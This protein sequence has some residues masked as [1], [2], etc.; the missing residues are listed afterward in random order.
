F[1][2]GDRVYVYPHGWGQVMNPRGSDIEIDIDKGSP[3][4]AEPCR[5]SFTEYDPIKGGLSHERPEACNGWNQYE[6]NPNCAK[7][8][9]DL[10]DVVR[11]AE[12]E[13]K[14]WSVKFGF[15]F[16]QADSH[17]DVH[18][19][20]CFNIGDVS[21][22]LES[23]DLKSI[24]ERRVNR[25]LEKDDDGKYKNIPSAYEQKALDF[26]EQKL[27]EGYKLTEDYVSIEGLGDEVQVSLTFRKG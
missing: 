14:E 24:I 8:S 2:E 13:S 19:K 20:G 15:P 17:G 25:K 21:F 7:K 4:Y 6:P 22:K 11:K 26:I 18:A 27:S 9:V 5:V 23:H 3:I 1:R 16:G 10:S 12:T